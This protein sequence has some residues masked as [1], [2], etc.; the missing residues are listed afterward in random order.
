MA[1]MTPNHSTMLRLLAAI[2][3]SS[4][5]AL[6][7]CLNPSATHLHVNALVG[8]Y[9]N[10]SIQCWEVEPPFKNASSSDSGTKIQNIGNIKNA[11]VDFYNQTQRTSV[12]GTTVDVPQYV[13]WCSPYQSSPTLLHFD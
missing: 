7:S 4:L 3:T 12:K 1:N 5:I 10:T 13:I 11:T 6:V 2:V 8:S 9:G